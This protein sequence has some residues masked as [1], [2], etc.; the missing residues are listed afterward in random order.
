MKKMSRPA[1]APGVTSPRGL[2]ASSGGRRILRILA[3]EDNPG[4]HNLLR[5]LLQRLNCEITCV[6]DGEEAVE[7]VRAGGPFD[8]VLMDIHMPVMN[9]YEAARAIRALPGPACRL[10]IIALSGDALSDVRD[11]ALDAG[12]NDYLGKP[13][14]AKEFSRMLAHWGEISRRREGNLL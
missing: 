6:N 14:D 5:L 11:L 13:I 2:A 10:P 4:F 1:M 8:L 3:A 12:M 9:G 7:A